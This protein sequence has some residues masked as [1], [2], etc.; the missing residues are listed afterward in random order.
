MRRAGDAFLCQDS[1][2]LYR[3][4]LFKSR[5]PFIR[6]PLSS[7][8]LS[9]DVFGLHPQV[10]QVYLEQWLLRMKKKISVLRVGWKVYTYQT[11]LTERL[12]GLVKLELA[13]EKHLG[14]VNGLIMSRD[15]INPADFPVYLNIWELALFAPQPQGTTSVNRD[16]M[17]PTE[18]VNS[19]KA[20]LIANNGRSLDL[21]CRVC[22]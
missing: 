5:N 16:K 8:G 20:A 3:V 19:I 2:D 10:T 13:E 14:G 7:V 4:L 1:P 15:K 11:S 12:V 21:R 9:E 17:C 18:A 6:S 22:R